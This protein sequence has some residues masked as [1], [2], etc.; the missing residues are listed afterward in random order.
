MGFSPLIVS[1]R[2]E[3]CSNSLG[4]KYNPG[5]CPQKSYQFATVAFYS[6]PM[7]RSA[8]VGAYSADVNILNKKSSKTVRM[9]HVPKPV[10]F[11]MKK[12][13]TSLVNVLNVYNSS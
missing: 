12:G 3:L 8:G 7:A 6:W 2:N 5:Q 13:C 9:I 1:F 10:D 4:L 11:K